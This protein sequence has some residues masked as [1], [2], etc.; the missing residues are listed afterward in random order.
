MARAG[1][2][3]SDSGD[4]HGAYLFTRDSGKL[5]AHGRSPNTPIALI[6]RGTTASQR[7]IRGELENLARLAQGAQS[8]S[9]IV[10]GEVAALADDLGYLPVTLSPIPNIWY[11][12]LKAVR[13]TRFSA[14]E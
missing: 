8:P 3:Q 4:L 5:L 9:L 13:P 12:W 11:H 14:T 6:E 1:G 2:Q 10:V 7:V